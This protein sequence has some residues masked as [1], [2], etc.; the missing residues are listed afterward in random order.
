MPLTLTLTKTLRFASSSFLWE[1]L[2]WVVVYL[3][4]KNSEN[5]HTVTSCKGCFGGRGLDTF[6]NLWSN[7]VEACRITRSGDGDCR[8]RTHLLFCSQVS[9]FEYSNQPECCFPIWLFMFQLW[10]RQDTICYLISEERIGSVWKCVWQFRI[11]F[12][13]A[14]TSASSE[15]HSRPLLAV[16]KDFNFILIYF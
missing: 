15:G 12:W 7:L 16:W 13:P 4:K 11:P 8:W 14:A 1:G 5:C 9:P 3:G 6:R 2:K 10:K